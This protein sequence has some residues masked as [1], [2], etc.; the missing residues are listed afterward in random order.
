M[1]HLP[2]VGD[3]AHCWEI[4]A[5]DISLEI[6]WVANIKFYSIF[7]LAQSIRTYDHKDCVV[8]HY[9]NVVRLNVILRKSRAMVCTRNFDRKELN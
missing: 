1:R 9:V 6:S 3:V 8:S 2:H 4:T 5:C 7:D